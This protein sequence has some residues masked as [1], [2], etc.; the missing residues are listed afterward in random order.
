MNQWLDFEWKIAFAEKRWKAIVMIF[1]KTK[2]VEK[3]SQVLK[4]SPLAS[5]KMQN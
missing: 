5:W 3:N 2:N 4:K 1:E